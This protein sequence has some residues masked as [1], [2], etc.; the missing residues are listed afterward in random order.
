[1]TSGFSELWAARPRVRT[2]FSWPLLA[3][4]LLVDLAFVVVS[5]V[6]EERFGLDLLDPSPWLLEADGGHSE[7]WGYVL[8]A[9]L[10][11]SLG[12]LAV[13]SRR[14]VWVG[15][16]LLFAAALA[17][18]KLR[19]HENK[20]AWLADRLTAHLWFPSD[21]FLG[22]RANDLGEILVWGLLSVV[23]LAVVVLFLRSS[24][25]WTRRANLG[26]A[27]LV[28]AYVFFG[29]VVDQLHVLFLDTPLAGSMGTIEDGGELVVLSLTVSYV[30]TLLRRVVR[31]RRTAPAAEPAPALV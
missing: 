17:D 29:G 20:G 19:L 5:V 21:G 10:A 31:E 25:R 24:D 8:Q 23:P 22:L 26:L 4:L 15:W 11:V 7:T 6:Y 1:M 18:D 27:V 30:A 9:A 14:P 13:L 12:T 16:A 28:A 2:L 3:G